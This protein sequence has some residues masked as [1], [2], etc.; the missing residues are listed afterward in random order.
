[1]IHVL[2]VDDDLDFLGL[3]ELKLINEGFKVSLA[4]NS[5]AGLE[6]LAAAKPD[7]I[8]LDVML[9]G[10]DGW[11]FCRQVRLT[12]NI[13][14]IMLT[15]RGTDADVVSGLRAGADE[16][17]TK[18]VRLGT[19]GARLEALV[20]RR[21]WEIESQEQEIASLKDSILDTFN[22]DLRSPATALLN[23]LDLAVQQAF[24]SDSAGLRR[25]V[26]EA[27]ENALSLR[28]L[29]DDLILL[30]RIDQGLIPSRRPTLL[31]PEFQS[32]LASFGLLLEER[33]VGVRFI[34]P[35]GL[36]GYIDPTLL[37][38]ALF[39]LL[40]N[41]IRASPAGDHVLMAAGETPQGEL[42]IEVRDRG[43]G[44]AEADREKIFERFY[45]PTIPSPETQHG[46]GIGLAIARAIA[47]A[48]QGD[49]TL[50]SLAGEGSIFH[51]RLPIEPVGAQTGRQ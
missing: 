2:V 41:A 8:L 13:P 34:C 47:R 11:D 31:H 48:H 24:R 4:E 21:H 3:I 16:Y 17:L 45:Q 33:D 10:M 27:R 1:M 49:L 39:H 51:L 28:Q 23:T 44:V 26:L 43:L 18:P 30:T 42:F 40:S 35:E 36:S 32:L 5:S 20:R 25:F 15:A 38:Q 14:V 37:R 7:I 9:P 50:T 12:S 19:L 46:L 29:I 22:Q 6:R